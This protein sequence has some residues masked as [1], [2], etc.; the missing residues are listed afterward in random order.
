MFGVNQL[1]VGDIELQGSLACEWTG[2][3]VGCWPS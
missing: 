3:K 2:V 1:I